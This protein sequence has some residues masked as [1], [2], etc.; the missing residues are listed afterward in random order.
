MK[1]LEAYF[2]NYPDNKILNFNFIIHKTK[3]YKLEIEVYVYDPDIDNYFTTSDGDIFYTSN[4]QLFI[5]LI[6]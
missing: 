6:N 2:E 4:N 5:A 3:S 1:N